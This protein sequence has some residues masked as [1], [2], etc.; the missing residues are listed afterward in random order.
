EDARN[1]APVVVLSHSL[2]L[3]K[4]AGDSGIVGRA[5][6]LNSRPTTVVGVMRPGFDFPNRSEVWTPQYVDPNDFSCWCY[7]MIGRMRP[8]ITAPDV[9][10]EMASII[11][12]FG[13]RRRDVF[14]DHKRGDARIIAMPLSHRIVGDLRRPL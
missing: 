6:Q 2:W 12:D 4:F 7:S 14:P 13:E 9:A 10:R 5:I 3:R 11:D 8:G 1:A